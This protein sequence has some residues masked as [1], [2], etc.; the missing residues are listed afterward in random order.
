MNNNLIC[1]YHGE[2]FDKDSVKIN[3]ICV[4]KE[5]DTIHEFGITVCPSCY[6]EL[7]K[8]GKDSHDRIELPVKQ[9]ALYKIKKYLHP[10][11]KRKKKLEDWQ[12]FSPV[13]TK[14]KKQDYK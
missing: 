11:M 12:L 5:N 2:P 10:S 6:A 1:Q 9:L 7:C 14:G 13:H 3:T 8:H 4:I